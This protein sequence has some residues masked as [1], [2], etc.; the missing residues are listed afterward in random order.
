M[1]A[2]GFGYRSHIVWAKPR[3]GTGYWARSK[4]ELL[5][6]GTRGDIPAPAPGDRPDSIIEAPVGRHSEKPTVFAELIERLYP[7][8]PKI[9][10]FARRARPGWTAWGKECPPSA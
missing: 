1:A 3:A 4:H 8:L 7:T 6:I 9:E 5:L 10:L 2:W